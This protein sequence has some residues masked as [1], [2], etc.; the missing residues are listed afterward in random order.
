MCPNSLRRD[1]K[2]GGCSNIF[3]SNMRAGGGVLGACVALGGGTEHRTYCKC[4]SYG[5]LHDVM[6]KFKDG[7]FTFED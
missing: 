7:K 4:L 2:R 5:T 1:N 6:H 3:G